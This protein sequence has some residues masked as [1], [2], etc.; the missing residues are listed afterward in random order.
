MTINPSNQPDDQSQRARFARIQSRLEKGKAY[1]DSDVTME[2]TEDP[3]W[4]QCIVYTV[5][6][7]EA[8]NHL[9]EFT[10]TFPSERTVDLRLSIDGHFVHEIAGGSASWGSET[11]KELLKMVAKEFLGTTY[12]GD[13][14]PGILIVRMKELTMMPFHNL[15]ATEAEKWHMKNGD[16]EYCRVFDDEV[17]KVRERIYRQMGGKGEWKM[18]DGEGI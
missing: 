13:P 9:V 3:K 7:G 15:G 8:G 16:A 12:G 2:L 6:P 14:D 1:L 17:L 18:G 4:G 10:E 11:A 5:K